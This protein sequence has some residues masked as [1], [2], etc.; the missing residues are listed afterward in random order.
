ML[1]PIVR[2][3]NR[4]PLFR[5]DIVCLICPVLC[6]PVFLLLSGCA[7]ES[8]RDIRKQNAQQDKTLYN[9][10]KPRQLPGLT[11]EQAVALGQKYNL[12]LWLSRQEEAIRRE[13]KTS[14][15]LKMLPSLT[16]DANL[17]TRDSYNA[18]SSRGLST[19]QE[20]QLDQYSY[21]AEKSHAYG[22][23]KLLF[24]TLDFGVA[25]FRA[26]QDMSRQKQSG[27]ERMRIGQKLA[28]DIATAYWQCV[29]NENIAN[30]AQQLLEE[31]EQELANLQESVKSGATGATDALERSYLLKSQ[32]V[33]INEYL[34]RRQAARLNL[35]Q[36]TGLPLDSEFSLA[37]AFSP[38]DSAGQT[39]DIDKL[40]NTA[41]SQRP[42]FFQEDL[43]EKITRD[44]ARAVLLSMLPSPSLFINPQADS[45]KYL[46][47][48]S[49]FSAGMNVSW[50]L[51]NIPGKVFQARAGMKQLDFTRKKRMALAVA[52]ITQVRLAVIEHDFALE[53]CRL[54][55]DLNDD[56][57]KI[58]DNL[59]EAARAGKGKGNAVVT[60]K[61]RGLDDFAKAQDA[62][63]RV[64]IARAKIEQSIG[65]SLPLQRAQGA[66]ST[67]A[68]AIYEQAQSSDTPGIP[69]EQADLSGY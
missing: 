9:E 52:V 63:A 47:Y 11:L 10:N 65:S 45:N 61:A 1:M 13:N 7:T 32:K 50:N 48:S 39:Y 18:S 21:S 16:F 14:A 64:M 58:T 20:A 23:M 66:A 22:G 35:L 4:K 49:W 55:Q 15:F 67:F 17:E 25:Y 62:L 57:R 33:K 68:P 54:L 42:E 41:L 69:G 19:G 34:E 8:D 36:I 3:Q 30:Q 24:N 59:A 6:I 40:E 44:E 26:K 29:S 38:A 56:S 2:T 60:Q 53:R 46:Y 12:D 31:F 43:S 27:Y 37:D 28:A 51:L 5:I